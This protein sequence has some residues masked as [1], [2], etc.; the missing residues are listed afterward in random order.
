MAGTAEFVGM[1]SMTGL[2]AGLVAAKLDPPEFAATA[3]TVSVLP[4]SAAT[5]T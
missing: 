1:M 4:T 3:A 5:G 2:V